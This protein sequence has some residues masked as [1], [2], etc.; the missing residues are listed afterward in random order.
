MY[1]RIIKVLGWAKS[2]A[3]LEPHPHPHPSPHPHPQLILSLNMAIIEKLLFILL[4]PTT[5]L[6]FLMTLV[7]LVSMVLALSNPKKK[8][9]SFLKLKFIIY[10]LF[11]FISGFFFLYLIKINFLIIKTR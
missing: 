10:T 11:I 2:S 5:R 7:L 3:A 9:S 1:D 4:A 8:H 6:P